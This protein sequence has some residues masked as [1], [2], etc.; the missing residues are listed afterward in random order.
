M[1]WIRKRLRDNTLVIK[2]YA[3][4]L[5]WNRYFPVRKELGACGSNSRLEYPVCFETR[6]NVFLEEN[7]RIRGGC[8]IINSAA[9]K[10]VIKKYS[11]LAPNCTI[12]TN[13]HRSTVTVPHFLLG[14][15]HINDKSCDIIIE[16][17]VWVGAN[18]VLLPGAHLGRGCI[19]G[20]GSVVSK[21]IPPYAL[22]VGSPA[23]VIQKKFELSD[24]LEHEKALYCEADRL[25]EEFLRELY[26]EH[27]EGLKTYGTAEGIDDAARERLARLKTAT[28]FVEPC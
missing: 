20:A 15:S 22:A 8:H 17:D 4:K 7:V 1:S 26:A 23:K 3:L 28:R 14:A 2:L 21:P 18:V 10:V 27:F 25:S 24:V 16:E 13:S 9:E 6:G 5:F 19:I 11:V 12:I